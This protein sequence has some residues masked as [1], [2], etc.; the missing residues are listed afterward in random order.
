MTQEERIAKLREALESVQHYFPSEEEAE[1]HKGLFV[2]DMVSVRG[3]LSI[4]DDMER[5][6]WSAPGSGPQIGDLV[7]WKDGE[8]Y[9]TAIAT[10]AYFRDFRD[11][12]DVVLM[13]RAELERR[14]S[15]A[16]K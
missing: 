8:S 1:T 13:R 2:A 3:A 4:L 15:E 7:A 16:T 6:V 10:A 9:E 14:I 5:E 11:A 12:G